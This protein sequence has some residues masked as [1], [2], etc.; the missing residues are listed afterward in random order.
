MSKTELRQQLKTC[1]LGI[2]Q[3]QRQDKSQKACKHLFSMEQFRQAGT[4]MLYLSLPYEIDTSEAILNCWQSGKTVAVPKISWEQRHMIPVKINS[5]DTAFS[6]GQTGLRNPISGTPVPFEEIDLVVTPALGFDRKGNR[7]GRGG[8][9]YDK[10]FSHEKLHAHKCGFAYAEQI[11]D[12]IPVTENDKPVDS[13]VTDNGV[14]F[15]NS[16]KGD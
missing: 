13:L 3:Q 6:T 5:L 10:F 2:Q 11:I 12:S 16:Q 7:L 9:Y 15:F 4:V 14:I 1:L 8:A